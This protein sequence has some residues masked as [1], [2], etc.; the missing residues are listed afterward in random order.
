M[1]NPAVGSYR[2]YLFFSVKDQNIFHRVD[3]IGNIYRWCSRDKIN[4]N[5]SPKKTPQILCLFHAYN[6]FWEE[7]YQNPAQFFSVIPRGIPLPHSNAITILRQ[8]R[9][10]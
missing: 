1:D 9:E 6:S 4:F 8:A 3:T 2:G 5:L 10:M 7:V